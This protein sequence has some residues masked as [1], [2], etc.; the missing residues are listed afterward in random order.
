MVCELPWIA[1]MDINPVIVD[2]GG[3]VAVD[4]RVVL[5]P[6]VGASPARHAHMAIMPYPAHLTRVLAAPDGGFYTL[7]AIQSEDADRLEAFMKNLSAESRYFRFISVLSEL[8]PRMLVRYTQID[9]DRELA[10]VA[11]V[12]GEQAGAPGRSNQRAKA[13][14]AHRRR[15]ALSAQCRSR[16]LR[17]RGCDRRRLAGQA[18]GFDDDARDHRGGAREGSAAHR[19]LCAVDQ[20]PDAGPDASPR[21]HGKDRPPGCDDEAGLDAAQ[22]W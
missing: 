9:Y 18:P 14:G 19:G 5:D 3:L 20:C 16:E 2:E 22:P 10:L 1:E 4:A 7:R 6:A 17:I 15:G 11:V 12:G 21:V 13:P 8:P